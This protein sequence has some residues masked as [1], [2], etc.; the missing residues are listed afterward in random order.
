MKNFLLHSD[1]NSASL[2]SSHHQLD[3]RLHQLIEKHY[4]S[5]TEQVEEVTL[6]KRKLAL[7]DQMRSIVRDYRVSTVAPPEADTILAG[8]SGPADAAEAHR[9][10]KARPQTP[11]AHSQTVRAIPS[12]VFLYDGTDGFPNP[13]GWPFLGGSLILAIVAALFFG[14][15]GA[16]LFSSS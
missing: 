5:G 12:A 14:G 4:L 7:K 13:A 6:K 8:S 16:V 1:H 15:G 2:P 10:R 9:A 3:D 11:A